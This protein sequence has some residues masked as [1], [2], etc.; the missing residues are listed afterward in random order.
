M[1]KTWLSLNGKCSLLCIFSTWWHQTLL[2]RLLFCSTSQKKMFICNRTPQTSINLS[3]TLFSVFLCS[4]SWSFISQSQ[5]WL[6]VKLC[7]EGQ[8]PGVT[9]SLLTLIPVFGRYI[10]IK[11][12]VEHLCDC[13]LTQLC[14]IASSFFSYSGKI[15]TFFEI[16]LMSLWRKLYF[17]AI[18]I[19]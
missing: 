4:I 14:I 3:I 8:Y 16:R 2:E 6:F 5:T 1:F 17:L 7:L 19:L 11:L 18:W 10:L 13:L 9:S 12:L 15:F